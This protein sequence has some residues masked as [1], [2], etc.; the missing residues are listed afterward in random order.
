MYCSIDIFVCEIFIGEILENDFTCV[1]ER[2]FLAFTKKVT[3]V[4]VYGKCSSAVVNAE[5]FL[6]VI[7]SNS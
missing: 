4:S 6:L 5:T 1:T 7:Y 3:F 2:T